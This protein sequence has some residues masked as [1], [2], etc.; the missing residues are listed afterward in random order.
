MALVGGHPIDA[1]IAA[2][3]ACAL[4]G[5]LRF[6][7]PPATIF[8]GDTGSMLIGLVLGVLAIRSSLKGPTTVALAA[9]A[10]IM[11]IPIFDSLAAIIRRVL[12]GRSIYT[13][14]RGHLHHTMLRRG[15]SVRSM[16]LAVAALCA[17]TAI[18]ALTSVYV[19]NELVALITVA[20][21]IGMLI[22][23]R[24]FGFA[25]FVLL[26]NRMLRFG[27]SLLPRLSSEMGLVRQETVRLQGS[28][29]WD[30]LWDSLT[31]FAEKHQLSAVRLE[32][33]M[34]WL[35]EGFH[36]FWE[37]PIPQEARDIWE[38]KL[39]LAAHGRTLGRLE[40]AGPLTN[41][42]IYELLSLLAEL[43]E[44]LEPC[45]HRLTAE[46]PVDNLESN[47]PAIVVTRQPEPSETVSQ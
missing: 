27:G 2:A 12:T 17:I 6:N 29:N 16:L 25:E 46:L 28:R 4:L 22:A 21:V 43:L 10:A 19:N 1:M 38:T 7:F 20:G 42:S 13:T 3:L 5:F 14:D 47:I 30:E 8:L 9:P 11:A 24:I 37:R 34:S 44:S 15:M 41:D 31:E 33:T 18:G 45:I 36:A 26:S 23:F 32:L 39:P 40:I 35:H